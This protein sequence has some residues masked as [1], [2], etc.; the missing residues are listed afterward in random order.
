MA[1]LSI[2]MDSILSIERTYTFILTFF[3]I[4]RTWIISMD[5]RSG[6]VSEWYTTRIFSLYLTVELDLL[7]SL[8]L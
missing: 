4:L 3:N 1:S 5:N 6:T 7:P 8:S 2:F